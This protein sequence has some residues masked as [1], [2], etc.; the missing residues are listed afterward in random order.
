MLWSRTAT[1]LRRAVARLGQPHGVRLKPRYAKVAEF[2]RRGAVHFHALVRLDALDPTGRPVPPPAWATADLLADLVQQA[3]R[4]VHLRTPTHPDSFDGWPL[5]WGPQ[6]DTRTVHRGLES[7]DLTERHVA[8]YLAKY[9]TKACEPSGLVAGRIT[10]VSIG[11]Y[12]DTGTFLG[13]LISACWTLGRRHSSPQYDAN[14]E[15]VWPYERCRRWAHML[16]FGG[17]FSTKS[18]AYSTTLRALREARQPGKRAAGPRTDDQA[19]DLAQRDDE[20]TT[21]VIGTWTYTGSGWMT[22][23]DAALALQAADAARS[24]R[25]VADPHAVAR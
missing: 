14:G 15:A 17:H 11:H 4:S 8:G 16:G 19:H 7:G 25:L 18:R 1:V 9:A 3:G 2:Q 10:D 12:A 22:T 24:R 23:G 6:L 5:A 13:R 21:L 20:E